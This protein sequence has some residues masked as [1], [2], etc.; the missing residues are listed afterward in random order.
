MTSPSDQFRYYSSF[1]GVSAVGLGALGAHAFHDTLVKK[2]MLH[3][4]QTAI[5][6]HLFHAVAVLGVSALC[7]D[8]PEPSTRLIQAGNL[9]TTGATLFSGSIYLLCFGIGPKKIV[10]PTTPIGG[11]LMI[12]GWIMLGLA[13]PLSKTQKGN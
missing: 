6:Y 10:G 13:P 7:K 3:S 1:L 8:D 4:W 12:G 9:M 2:N 5:L 11:L